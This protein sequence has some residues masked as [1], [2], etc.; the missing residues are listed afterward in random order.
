M[1][2]AILTLLLLAPPPQAPVMPPP[3]QAPA[4]RDC[5]CGG[6][7]NCPCGPSCPCAV[8]PAGEE[9]SAQ[10]PAQSPDPVA[11]RW[12]WDGDRND[13][14]RELLVHGLAAGKLSVEGVYYPYQRDRTG[15]RMGR[16]GEC[17]CQ[18]P[19]D[20]APPRG[21]VAGMGV[22]AAAYQIAPQRANLAVSGAVGAG[23][24]GDCAS[25]SCG[26]SSAPAGRGLFRGRR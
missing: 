26:A 1:L 23:A 5:G 6:A 22:G 3:P 12:V 16:A 11:Y 18:L 14:W 20:F 19:T 8:A 2:P 9:S 7:G 4:A 25:G 24:G 17:P 13:G 15:A 21:S 10:P